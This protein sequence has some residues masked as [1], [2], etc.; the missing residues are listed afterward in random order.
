MA[1][2]YNANLEVQ[3]PQQTLL[4]E[5]DADTRTALESVW[6]EKQYRSG[7]IILDAEETSIEVLFLLE[8]AVRV[9]NFSDK[10]REVSFST[11]AEGDCFG[12][13]AVIDH[14][15]RS[16]SVVALKDCKVAR[17]TDS[18]FRDLLFTHPDMCFALMKRLVE[19]LRELTRRV[20]D[21]TALRAD[22][23]IRLEI[24]RLFRDSEVENGS[25]ELPKPPTQSELAAFVFT[26]R[27]AVAR[28]IGRMKKLDLVQRR[29]R[30]LFTPSV[31]ALETYQE[32]QQ[33]R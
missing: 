1:L 2:K 7:Q 6:N 29:G 3:Y 25:S 16:A 18:Q 12:E 27:E 32:E 22:D 28:E 9:A 20:S 8:G 15:P 13:F 14:A 17:I 23:R 21:F 19:K 4:G 24:I 10:G 31:D 26:N 11:I 33:A 30:G 5:V